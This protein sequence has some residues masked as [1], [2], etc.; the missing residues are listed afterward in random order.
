M[1]EQLGFA[2]EAFEFWRACAHCG[3]RYQCDP[4]GA[5]G[6]P[7][8]FCSEACRKRHAM[9]QRNAWRRARDRQKREKRIDHE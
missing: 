9:D 8:V 4:P 5:L 2:G 1:A 6:R 3:A 7:K